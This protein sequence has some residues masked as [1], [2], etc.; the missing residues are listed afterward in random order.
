MSLKD[1][2]ERKEM[3][4]C[5]LK[6]VQRAIKEHVPIRHGSLWTS[7]EDEDLRDTFNVFLMGK[8]SVHARTEGAILERLRKLFP[9]MNPYLDNFPRA[10]MWDTSVKAHNVHHGPT[11]LSPRM[12]N[13]LRSSVLG[14]ARMKARKYGLSIHDIHE[15]MARVL[16]APY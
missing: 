8:A 9:A 4:E 1:L 12:E 3:L 14:F 16:Q 11:G 2:Q 15:K 5:E 6:N 10:T 7:E 13:E